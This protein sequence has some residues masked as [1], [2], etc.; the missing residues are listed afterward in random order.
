MNPWNYVPVQEFC[1]EPKIIHW[2]GQL[3]P[4]D[5]FYVLGKEKFLS[6]RAE[7]ARR[8]NHAVR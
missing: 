8:S 4:W 5:D 1:E 7:L 6:I 3:K 2:A